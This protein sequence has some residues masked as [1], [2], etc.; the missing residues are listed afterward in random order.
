MNGRY[1]KIKKIGEGAQAKVFL[2][3]DTN[4]NNENEPKL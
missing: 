1:K 3:E 2:V 4:P